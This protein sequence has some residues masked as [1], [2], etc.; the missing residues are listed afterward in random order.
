MPGPVADGDDSAAPLNASSALTMGAVAPLVEN[1][2]YL[3]T[4][5]TTIVTVYVWLRLIPEAPAPVRDV[6]AG[7]MT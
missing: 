2:H 5:F 1:E 4:P 6:M 3:D 7:G